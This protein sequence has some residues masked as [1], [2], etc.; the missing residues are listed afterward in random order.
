MLWGG[1]GED[2]IG[3]MRGLPGGRGD[4]MERMRGMPGGDEMG[5]MRGMPGGLPGAVRVASSYPV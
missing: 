1:C 2:E 4:E 3:R 5:R